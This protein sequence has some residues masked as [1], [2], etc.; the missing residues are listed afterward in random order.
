MYETGFLDTRARDW[1]TK[2]GGTEV[3]HIYISLTAMV[4]G[5]AMRKTCC[6]VPKFRNSSPNACFKPLLVLLDHDTVLQAHSLRHFNKLHAE[7]L[8]DTR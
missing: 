3:V 1:I 5:D 8:S 2:L 6:Q 7:A 4:A